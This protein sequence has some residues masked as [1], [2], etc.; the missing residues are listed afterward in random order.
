MRG[1][2]P[3][4]MTALV[5]LFLAEGQRAFLASLFGLGYEALFP[6]FRLVPALIALGFLL[7]ILAPLLP[8]AR[9]LDRRGAVVVAAAACAVFRVPMTHPALETRLIGGALVLAAGAAFLAWAVGYVDRRALTGGVVIGLVVDQL[10]RLAGSSYDLS[11]QP[12]WLPVQ[13]VLSLLLLALVVPWARPRRGGRAAEPDPDAGSDDDDV[14]E[15][16]TGGLRLRGALALGALLFMDLHV[17]GLAPVVARWAG[18]EHAFAG[19]ALGLAGALA[20]AAT[21]LLRRPTRG[22]IVI[23]LLVALT[24]IAALVGYWLEGVAVALLMAGGHMAALL[25]VTRALEPASGRRSSGRVVAGLAVLVVATTLYGLTFYSAFTVPAME[26]GAPWI[27]GAVGVLL[28]GCFVLL[29]RPAV[30]PSPPSR[31]PT[32]VLAAGLALLAIA[33]PVVTARGVPVASPEPAARTEPAVGEAVGEAVVR[34]ATWNLHYGFDGRWRFDP[35]AVAGTLRRTGADLVALQEVPVGAP[36]AYGID[37]PLWLGRSTGLRPHFSPTINGLLGDAFLTRLDAAR[38]EAIPL[39]AAGGDRKQLLRLTADV[40]GRRVGF[41]GLHLGVRESARA[42][43]LREALAWIEAGPSV[44]LGDLNAEAG[45]PVTALLSEAG[46]SDAFRETLPRPAT[47]PSHDPT[48]RI[49]WIWVRGLRAESPD[50]LRDAGS[51]HL[52]V[53]ATLHIPVARIRSTDSHDLQE[54]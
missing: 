6:A 26:G 44:V 27:F 19:T 32:V 46:F 12:G 10:L 5:S 36:M 16:R 23:L 53:V 49:D 25:L 17:L 54:P 7:T 41:Y 35:A 38:M 8:L 42:A 15:R 52:A 43:Q 50:V 2:R 47:F 48:V 3:L 31:V 14:L 9:W 34:V 40:G 4:V 29:P 33:I 1:T 13:G 37:L 22:R 20:V 45:S 24:A 18:V 28:A 51:D 11:L 21:L 30:I 39:P